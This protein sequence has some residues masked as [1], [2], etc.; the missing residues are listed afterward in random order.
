MRFS[1]NA[2]WQQ[3]HTEQR[4]RAIAEM[5]RI[6]ASRIAVNHR[7]KKLREHC[8]WSTTARKTSHSDKR[9]SVVFVRMII[10]F[11]PHDF[12][13]RAAFSALDMR[14]C[15]PPLALNRSLGNETDQLVFQI[16]AIKARLLYLEVTSM[17]IARRSLGLLVTIICSVSGTAAWAQTGTPAQPQA[18]TPAQPPTPVPFDAAL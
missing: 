3:S 2:G 11:C 15:S 16:I 4:A 8:P 6:M 13:R 17:K 12:S 14:A 18:A 10:R 1:A 9:H 5:A 7:I